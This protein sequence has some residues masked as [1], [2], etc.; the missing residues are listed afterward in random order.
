LRFYA[1]WHTHTCYSHGVGTVLDNAYAAQRRGLK[2][3]AIA[4]HGPAN[5]FGVGV[6]NL[7]TFACIRSDIEEAKRQVSGVK[8]LYAAEAN[9]IDTDGTIDIPLPMQD[10]FDLL[11]I[12]LHILVK[13]R[14][15]WRAMPIAYSNI[16]AKV[17]RQGERQALVKNTDMLVAAV[18]RNRVH[19]VTHPG[20]RLPIDTRELAKA[21]VVT[22]TAME[23]NSGHRHTTCDY[24]RRAAETGVLFAIGSDAHE[25]RR[26]GDLTA[27]WNLARQAGLDPQQILN[28]SPQG[29]EWRR[30]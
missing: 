7:D 5:L 6:G 17:C 1:D 22:G 24:L 3:I 9:V 28:V 4:D 29:R 2:E 21:C 23:I 20:Y 19:I 18:H 25:P 30:R 11:L 15:L 26:V 13:P 8:V 12:G 10:V 16:M 27:G 14:S